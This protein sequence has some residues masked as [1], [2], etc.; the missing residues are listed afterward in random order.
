MN[1]R[2]LLIRSA[3][4][5]TAMAGA[6]TA[7]AQTTA[8]STA[9]LQAQAQAQASMSDLRLLPFIP[10]GAVYTATN[11][12]DGN[13]I[14]VFERSIDGRLRQA[15]SVKTGGTGSGAGLGSQGSIVLSDNER[16]LLAVNAGSNDVSVF[17]VQPRG[18][19][20]ID[21]ADAGGSQP[22]GVAIHGSLVYVVNAGTGNISG[23]RLSRRGQLESLPGSTRALSQ[24]DAGP[25][26][27]AFNA[28][29]DRLVVT[30][31]NTNRIVTFS[32]DRDGLPGNAQV[33]RAAGT[34]P[35]G[36]A[37]GRRDRL[38]V[39]EAFGGAAGASAVSSYDLDDDGGIHTVSASVATRQTSACW[40]A[41]TPDGRFAYA[42]N[43]GSGSITGYA[44]GARGD[45]TRL[46]A[47]GRTGVTGDGAAPADLA[48]SRGGQFLYSMNPGT[49]KIVAF[50][51][52]PNGRLIQLSTVS[53]LPSTVF[54]LAAR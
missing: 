7:Y 54:G 39:S 18:L 25:A 47:D 4:I 35:F 31:K 52:A 19:R 22:I 15:G 29:G 48:L 20:L 50:F 33:Q 2:V 28:D 38:F 17:D 45:L 24:A 36:F 41:V 43:T 6:A 44:I 12:A 46:D 34:T 26:E 30:E 37:I 14:L 8:L 1:R 49:Q 27:I 32:I 5:V 42:A 40:V 16:W 23:F 21:R 13:A 53:N 3:L 51:V 10:F 9:L 11:A